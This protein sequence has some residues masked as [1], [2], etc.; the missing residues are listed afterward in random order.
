MRE[1]GAGQ[2]TLRPLGEH[3]HARGDVRARLVVSERL[4]V[5]AE[6]LVARADAEHA[7]VGDEQ[8]LRGGLGQDRRPELLRLLGEEA[9]ELR[10][11]DDEVAV[12][13]H[14]RRGGD[15]QG[16]LRGQEVDALVRDLA[17]ARQLRDP[18]PVLE[19]A[20]QRQRVDDRAG[21]QVRART[22]ALLEDRDRHVAEP[23]GRLGML[24]E[25][26]SEADRAR[27]PGGAGADDQQ[28]DL[29]PL[30]GRVRRR[31]ERLL[32]A[33]RRRVVGGPDA[34]YPPALGAGG[35]PSGVLRRACAHAPCF[36]RISSVSF[37]TT[38]CTSPTT[39]RSENSKIGAFASLLIETITFAPCM[40]TL[41]WI[42]PEMPSAT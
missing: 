14:R 30:V 10:D 40:P 20:P 37:G 32:R 28:A 16:A 3:G 35:R 27:E 18:Q 13:P 33:P 26:L 1:R 41:C 19:E 7:A 2:M 34:H 5:A 24:R 4:A 42:A 12:V 11:R 39:P 8:L 31:R 36:C 6:P 21:E 17:V 25:Q 15:P 9:A 38:A 22:G 29:D 23:L